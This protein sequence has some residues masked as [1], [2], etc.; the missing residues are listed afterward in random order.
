MTRQAALQSRYRA[1]GRCL[2]CGAYSAGFSLCRRHRLADNDRA[3]A[4]YRRN[5]WARLAYAAKKRK[6]RYERKMAID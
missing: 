3:K 5:R 1:A 4:Y 6:E 2:C